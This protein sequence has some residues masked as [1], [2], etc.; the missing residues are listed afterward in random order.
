MQ[1]RAQSSTGKE[2]HNKQYLT[3]VGFQWGWGFKILSYTGPKRNALRCYKCLTELNDTPLADI[4]LHYT[5]SVSKLPSDSSY[6]EIGFESRSR[7]KKL[8][9][10]VCPASKSQYEREIVKATKILKTTQQ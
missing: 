5:C 10:L 1:Q 7:H 8:R 6:K 9:D 2:G 3:R 4:T